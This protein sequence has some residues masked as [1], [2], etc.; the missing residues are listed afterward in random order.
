MQFAVIRRAVANDYDT[1]DL[2]AWCTWKR[3]TNVKVTKFTSE[4]IGTVPLLIQHK[5]TIGQEKPR[6]K[7]RASSYSPYKGF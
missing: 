2:T 6:G 5:L 4:H 7:E 3:G 1:L